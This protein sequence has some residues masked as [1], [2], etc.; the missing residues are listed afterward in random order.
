METLSSYVL[1]RW[2]AGEG[3]TRTL[4][5]PSNEEPLA[6]CGTG[7]IDF[8]AVLAHAREIGGPALRALGFEARGKLL[9]ALSGAIHEHRDELLDLSIRCAGT[10]RGDAKFDVDG[11]TGTLAAY[12]Y[13]A[14]EISSQGFLAVHDKHVEDRRFDC[15][16]C[17]EFGGVSSKLVGTSEPKK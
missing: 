11:A 3:K 1:G 13:F 7:G 16:T 10:T 8:G 9:K 17:H 2:H 4:V 12:A 6:E 14:K 5:D 15:S